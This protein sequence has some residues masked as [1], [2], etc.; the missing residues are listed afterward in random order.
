MRVYGAAEQLVAEVDLLVPRARAVK[1][2]A[3]K[4]LENSV[5][6]VLYNTGE[7][8]GSFKP[9]VKITAYDV[10]RKEANEVRTVLRRLVIGRVFTNV[11]IAKAYNLAGAVIGMLRNAIKALESRAREQERG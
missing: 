3:A 8:I 4:H 9:K 6:S 7:G 10:A 11:E 1:P 5:E 2:N